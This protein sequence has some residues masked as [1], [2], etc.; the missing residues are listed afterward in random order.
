MNS[1]SDIERVLRV[2]AMALL[3][4]ALAKYVGVVR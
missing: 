3:C 1:L 2:A 4:W